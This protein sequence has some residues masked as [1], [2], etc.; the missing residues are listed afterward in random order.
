MSHETWCVENCR[1]RDSSACGSHEHKELRQTIFVPE[2]LH[3]G[4]ESMLTISELIG[5]RLGHGRRSSVEPC[6]RLAYERTCCCT[7]RVVRLHSSVGGGAV[8]VSGECLIGEPGVAAQLVKPYQAG[9]RERWGR[10]KRDIAETTTAE[11]VRHLSKMWPH[12]SKM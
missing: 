2:H 11:D 6:G 7:N 1:Q 3:K 4:T 10:G 12:L 9:S 5:T 8:G